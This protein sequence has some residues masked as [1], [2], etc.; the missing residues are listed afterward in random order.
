[1]QTVPS[2]Q[3]PYSDTECEIST[4][5]EWTDDFLHQKE[6][7]NNS[8]VSAT[9]NTIANN[10]T[11][12]SNKYE[13]YANDYIKFTNENPTTYH[14]INYFKLLLDKSG[15]TFIPEQKS[16]SA[17]TI[18]AINGGGLFYT[19]RSD[20]TL[21][22]FVIG[23]AW[24]P[25][26]GLGVIGSHVDSLTAKLKPFTKKP[27]VDGYQL[28]GVAPY[29]G[30]LNKLW[31]DRDLGIG[32]KILIKDKNGRISSKVIKSEYPIAKIP[33]LAEHFINFEDQNYNQETRMVPIVGYEE[34]EEE[35]IKLTEDE[36]R[37]PLL[38][39]HSIHLLRFLSELS[40]TPISDI[41]QLDLELYDVQKASRGGISKEFIFA[42]RVDDRLCSYTAIHS[43][44]KFGQTVNLSTY[45]G[46]NVVDLTDNEEIGSATRTGVKGQFLNAT[47]DRI[48]YA[49]GFTNASRLVFANSL[50]VSADV[51]HALN[52]NFKSAYLNGH[53]P[54][55]N[56]GLTIKK[57][58]NNHV[59]SDSVGIDVFSRI[60]S[61]NGLKLQQFHI[62]NGAPS[63]G[64]IGPMISCDTGARV[65]DVGLAQ[66]SMHSIRAMFGYKEV[67][68]GI[69]TFGAFFKDWREIYKSYDI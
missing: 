11:I 67:G 49:K 51:T 10:H 19:V 40:N 5:E 41:I 21:V 30:A 18:E 32:G 15:Y 59:M 26:Q 48:L 24:T 39:K 22:A 56:K 64:T 23:G 17:S 63:G 20:L 33:S 29:S 52:P 31:L 43:L 12:N 65:V 14:V 36:K 13:V 69:D 62:R 16:L 46:C 44:I 47:L 68:I 66:L 8:N 60:A 7:K 1:M 50:I 61:K 54:V 9:S 3:Y 28:L 27:N 25:E 4:D 53:F 37:S 45:K 38:L 34:E 57:D 6:E 42:P 2:Q 35:S 58:A 55:P